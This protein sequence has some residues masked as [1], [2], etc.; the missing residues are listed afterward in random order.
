MINLGKSEWSEQFDPS[1]VRPFGKSCCPRLYFVG[2]APGAREVAE[3]RPFVGPAGQCLR[4]MLLE[5][6]ID[7]AQIRLANATPVRPI[8]KT[9]TGRVRNR[10]PSREEI[11]VLGRSVL[12]DIRCVRPYSIV[13]LGA[14]ACTLLDIDGPISRTRENAFEY[15][16]MP[17]QATYHPSYVRR[18]GRSR[19]ILH[20]QVVDDLKRCWE[21]AMKDTRH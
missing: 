18:F 11:R 4:E 9:T 13:A 20:D 3:G 15:E 7:L 8:E 17:V 1:E 19:P 12:A 21:R 14:S 10:S 16:G 2:E 5:A 6:G